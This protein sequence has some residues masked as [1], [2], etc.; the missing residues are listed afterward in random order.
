MRRKM[1]VQELPGKQR[2]QTRPATAEVAAGDASVAGARVRRG[3][4]QE[5]RRVGK[6]RWRLGRVRVLPRFDWTILGR[7]DGPIE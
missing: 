1:S 6:E 2:W 3:A 5:G 7:P 4:R